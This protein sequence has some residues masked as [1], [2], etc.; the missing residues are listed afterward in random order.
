MN[1]Q[2]LDEIQTQANNDYKL[3]MYV[4]EPEPDDDEDADAGHED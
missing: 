1:R 2:F 3:A 4:T